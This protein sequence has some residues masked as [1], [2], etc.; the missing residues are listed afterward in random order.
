MLR[1]RLSLRLMAWAIDLDLGRLADTHF[2]RWRDQLAA[3]HR[4]VRL[5]ALAPDGSP[6]IET[7]ER[8]LNH[9]E[10][11]NITGSIVSRPAA[12]RVALLHWRDH[13]D[14]ASLL[15]FCSLQHMRPRCAIRGSHASGRSR[16]GA[17]RSR[18]APCGRLVNPLAPA[19]FRRAEVMR[20]RS[21]RRTTNEAWVHREAPNG[22]GRAIAFVRC[23]AAYA[24]ARRSHTSRRARIT[25]SRRINGRLTF[26][27]SSLISPR[28][29]RRGNRSQALADDPTTSSTAALLP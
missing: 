12:T 26:A 11:T 27:S 18:P 9:H 20:C 7:I 19:V 25:S 14:R 24:R 8:P 1:A 15:R 21:M 10:R 17:R 23:C 29:W 22:C 5:G 4:R 3:S 6:P 13:V 28:K 2:T 16:F